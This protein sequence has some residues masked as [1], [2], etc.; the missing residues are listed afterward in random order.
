MRN[1]RPCP[2]QAE[3]LGTNLATA[4]ERA[5]IQ[6]EALDAWR[7]GIVQQLR[8]GS[9]A[10]LFAWYRDQDRYTS[11]AAKTRKDYLLIMNRLVD[12]PMKLGTLG[13]RRAGAVNATAAD[14]IYKR[15]RTKHGERQASYAMQVA[16]LVW[17]WAVRH[18]DVTGV[19]SNPFSGMGIA[20][21]PAEGNRETSRAEYDL[22]RK[23]ARELKWQSMA[24]AAALSFELCQR[25]WDV[26]GFE[27]PDGVK[28][29]GFIWSDYIE[30]VSIAYSQSK[31]GKAMTIPL[32]EEIGD[33]AIPLFPTLEEELALMPRKAL[34]IV[35]DEKTGLPLTYDQMNKRH[36]KI[37]DK[38]GLPK[39]MTF[40]GF[41]HGGS[42]ELGDAGVADIRPISGHLIL[43]TTAIYNK[44]NRVKAAQAAAARRDYVRALSESLSEQVS[45]NSPQSAS[46]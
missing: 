10:W 7:A 19:T 46:K 35:V 45:E 23:T 44:V 34:V 1:G 31:T 6:N 22:Y 33:E 24:T 36:R 15:W 17:N 29:R 41:R 11:K 16:R 32:V 42:T 37:C 25:V 12:E 13:Q 39:E 5:A 40:T 9:V 43:D 2:A 18:H 27:D 8:P 14:T 38:A 3:N 21:T 30:G 20:S 26:F 4:I 28:K